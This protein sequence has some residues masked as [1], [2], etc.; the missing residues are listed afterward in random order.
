MNASLVRQGGLHLILVRYTPAHLVEEE[1]VYNR[2]DIDRSRVVWARDS[3][4][5][6]S[7]LLGYY[8]NRKLW[9][10]DADVRP[11]E[12]KPCRSADH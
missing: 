5:G 1:W 11:L 10:L 2:A 9:C 7:K 8:R 4:P 12:L 3:G 6:N